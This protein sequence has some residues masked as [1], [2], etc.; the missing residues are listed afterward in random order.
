[1]LVSPP[2]AI[3]SSKSPDAPRL[4]RVTAA[5][6]FEGGV[7][8]DLAAERGQMA[9][10]RPRQAG[11]VDDACRGRE[12]SSTA[13]ELRLE[14]S[15]FRSGQSAQISDTVRLGVGGDRV[16]LGRFALVGRDEELTAAK[17][18]DTA[19]RAKLIEHRLA[20]NA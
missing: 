11:A 18:G 8:N 19:L 13:R 15:R 20:R 4:R 5:R 2:L 9:I 3:V 16:E 10:E 12:V 7:E 6:A 17:K 1:V 14:R